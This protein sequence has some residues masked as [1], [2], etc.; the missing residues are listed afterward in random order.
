M[1]SIKTKI[2]FAYTLIFGALLVIF[3][4]VIY[5][6]TRH[7]NLQK[8]D[9]RLL[10]YA[11]IMRAEIE[12]EN[13]DKEEFDLREI[14][15]IPAEGLLSVSFQLTTENGAT[16][17]SSSLFQQKLEL[18]LKKSYRDAVQFEIFEFKDE[19]FRCLVLP[20]I[21]RDGSRH[22]LK[23]AAS[24]R[25]VNADL[26]RM[27][28]L[29]I[30]LIPIAL[31]LTGLAAYFISKAAFKPITAMAETACEI[32]VKNLNIRLKLPKANDEVRLLGETLN[33][34][35]TRIEAAFKSHKQFIAS[36]SHELRTPLTIIQTE[37]ELAEKQLKN[38]AVQQNISTALSEV[39]SMNQLTQSLL[40]L[41]QIDAVP[42]RLYRG[43]FRLDELLIECIQ[44]MKSAALEKQIRLDL[45]IAE[46]IE[47]TADKEKIK[48]VCLNLLDNAIKYTPEKG[49]IRVGLAPVLDSTINF[50][51]YN[52]GPGISNKDLPNI[53]KRFYR[54]EETRSTVSGSGLG[55]AIVHEIL[56][57]HNGTI[58]A[59]ST[60][61]EGARFT[62]ALPLL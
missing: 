38:L 21:T 62:V 2:I 7:A 54:S 35:I 23:V 17:I 40:Q 57:M 51:V 46:A 11:T 4:N 15:S 18:H 44:A 25:D 1:F 28:G 19:R 12:E 56:T 20:V 13:L 3:A 45:N 53:F 5:H 30:I 33:E 16:I 50:Y 52:S 61:N 9:D 14:Q 32:S 59:T 47:V 42:E 10:S 58:S 60:P 27:F 22:V 31:I 55:L 8:F 39:E 26:N 36:A 48:R 29:F 24:L 49:V 43:P 6:S 34:M 41:S 37:L